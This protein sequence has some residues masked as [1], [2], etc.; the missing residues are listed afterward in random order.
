[1]LVWETP[2][3]TPSS[4][5]G[6]ARQGTGSAKERSHYRRLRWSLLAVEDSPP[7][8]NAPD[9]IR[10]LFYLFGGAALGFGPH[11]PK[12]VCVPFVAPPNTPIFL[13]ANCSAQTIAKL[14]VVD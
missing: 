2:I 13:L 14:V 10:Y 3:G 6:T 9:L 5:A 8:T 1:M 4:C 12:S 11:S 7:I